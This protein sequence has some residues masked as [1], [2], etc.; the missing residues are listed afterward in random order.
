MICF[1]TGNVPLIEI[2]TKDY[3]H[4]SGNL[5]FVGRTVVNS[6]YVLT[7]ILER[8]VGGGDIHRRKRIF[9]L[10]TEKLER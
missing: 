4:F 9:I 7:Y 5:F 10:K 8:A 6:F 2:K 3:F 1:L